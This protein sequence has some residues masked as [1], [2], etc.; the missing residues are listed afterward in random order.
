MTGFAK[1]ESKCCNTILEN[2]LDKSEVKKAIHSA[3]YDYIINGVAVL[4]KFVDANPNDGIYL[5]SVFTHF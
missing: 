4:N 5:N 3:H 1:T 2:A